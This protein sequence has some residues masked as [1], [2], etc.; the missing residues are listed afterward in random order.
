MP[1]YIL[2][3]LFILRFVKDDLNMTLEMKCNSQ[4]IALRYEHNQ[5]YIKNFIKI[6]EIFL[7]FFKPVLVSCHHVANCHKIKS[8]Q[9][10]PFNTSQFSSSDQVQTHRVFYS[11]CHTQNF[12][13]TDLFW[14]PWEKSISKIIQVVVR[15]RFLAVL[16]WD[17]YFLHDSQLSKEK[18]CWNHFMYSLIPSIKYALKNA[19]YQ[20]SFQTL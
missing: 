17:L 3:V 18:R 4:I 19:L 6:S 1:S 11:N 10:R 14:R 16:R 2:T 20:L 9:Q 15:I 8:F 12:H 13:Q 7:Q 5:H